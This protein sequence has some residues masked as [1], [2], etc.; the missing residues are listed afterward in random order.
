[1]RKLL[2][3]LVALSGACAGDHASLDSGSNGGGGVCDPE[4]CGPQLGMPNFTCADGSTGGPTGRCLEH[5][6]GQCGWEIRECPPPVPCGG[7]NVAA[8]AEALVCV[9][10]PGDACTY[11]ADPGCEGVCVAPVFCGGIAAIRCPG[12]RACVD[13]PRDDC[14]PP[15]GAD[16]GG[17]C[18]P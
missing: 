5:A 16:C 8:C 4:A 6:N 12:E 11:P 7:A 17:L 10:V 9:D 14:A 3:V 18:A 15:R 2:L 13:D 1:M